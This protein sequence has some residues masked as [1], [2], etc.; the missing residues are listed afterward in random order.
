VTE[1]PKARRLRTIAEEMRRLWPEWIVT[2][3]PYTENTDRKI[4][5]LRWP[6]KGRRG[7]LL[8]VRDEHYA[9]L[10]RHC[11]AETYRCN[12]EVEAWLE[13]RKRDTR[14]AD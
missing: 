6:G 1:K 5:R 12:A 13:A 14:G 10:L 2:V 7:T 8:T 3:E 11:S 9:L 4:G